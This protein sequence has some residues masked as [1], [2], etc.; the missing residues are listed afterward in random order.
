MD[1]I[2][3]IY[4]SLV[5]HELPRL[6]V[7]L[8]LR[9]FKDYPFS[10]TFLV[11]FKAGTTLK[12]TLP[13]YIQKSSSVIK[14]PDFW[15]GFSGIVDG[16]WHAGANCCSA[17]ACTCSSMTPW[18]EQLLCSTPAAQAHSNSLSRGES[19]TQPLFPS[20]GLT[21]NLWHSLFLFLLQSSFP[22]FVLFLKSNFWLIIVQLKLE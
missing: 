3:V 15:K 11:T 4:C 2:N 17:R 10:V 6:K 21:W 16:P 19:F 12:Q 18:L 5:V 9:L 13:W 22:C 20:V 8:S 1:F 14:Y 7:I